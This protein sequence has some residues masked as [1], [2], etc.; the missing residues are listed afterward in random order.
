[1]QKRSLILKFCMNIIF[2]RD[3]YLDKP[4]NVFVTI[5]A[6]WRSW[7]HFLYQHFCL[8]NQALTYFVC[9][10][11]TYNQALT[12][13]ICQWGSLNTAFATFWVI[14]RK[15]LEIWGK[16]Q[17]LLK[18]TLKQKNFLKTWIKIDLRKRALLS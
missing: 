13:K 14:T 18:R 16:V 5:F 17:E 4:C 8:A 3:M 6:P 1:M 7:H 10:S 12:Y 9:Q 15:I 11:L 2:D